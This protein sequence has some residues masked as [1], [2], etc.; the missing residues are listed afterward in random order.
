MAKRKRTGLSSGVTVTCGTSF[1]FRHQSQAHGQLKK[2]RIKLNKSA[3][4]L[5]EK[6]REEQA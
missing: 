5:A 1:G 4:E 3:K 6:K 2:Q